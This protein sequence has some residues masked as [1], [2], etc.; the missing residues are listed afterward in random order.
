MTTTLVL[1]LVGLLLVLLAIAVWLHRRYVLINVVGMSMQPAY[2]HG[3]RILVRRTQCSHV[4]RGQIVVF[5]YLVDVP[6]CTADDVTPPAAS[7]GSVRD[8]S[9]LLKRA[10]A[11]P[12]DP[13]PRDRIAS[14]QNGSDLVVPPEHLVVLG[15]NPVASMDSRNFGY[16]PARRVLGVVVRRMATTEG[17]TV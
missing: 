17:N 1:A 6:D 14:L 16:V 8:R 11:V 5:E 2:H 10:I 3:D 15:D 9:W 7:E 13:V 4:R 12:G